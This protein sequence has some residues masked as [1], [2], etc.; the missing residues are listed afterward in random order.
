[1]HQL[2]TNR[3]YCERAYGQV[4]VVIILIIRCMGGNSMSLTGHLL[5]ILDPMKTNLWL[6]SIFIALSGRATQHTQGA[7]KKQQE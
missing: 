1:M 6:R 5:R 7:I 3:V 2:R 4:S